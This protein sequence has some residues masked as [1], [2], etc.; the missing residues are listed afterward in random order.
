MGLVT[1]SPVKILGSVGFF[2]GLLIMV[3]FTGS[4]SLLSVSTSLIKAYLVVPG[5]TLFA[6][7]GMWFVVKSR[8]PHRFPI[9]LATETVT[10]A[11]GLIIIGMAMLAGE[12]LVTL[13]L[14]FDQIS[15]F[16]GIWTLATVW[17]VVWSLILPWMSAGLLS[18][19]S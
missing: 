19:G 2:M 8:Y 14:A 12:A 9:A 16:R 7:L 17:L 1:I 18:E 4:D 6:V 10:I 13:T 15:T 3:V 5:V 11:G